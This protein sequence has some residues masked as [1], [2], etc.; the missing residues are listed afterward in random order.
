MYDCESIMVDN[1]GEIYV[2]SKV[3]AGSKPLF[4]H[5][6]SSAWGLENRTTVHGGVAVPIISTLLDPVGGD[7]S[8]D[9]TEVFC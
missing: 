8:P 5:V 2:V 3:C 6:P 7:I 4:Q 1:Q 9:G